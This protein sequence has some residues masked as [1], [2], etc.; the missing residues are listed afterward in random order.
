MA[1][2][3][4]QSVTDVAHIENADQ[5]LEEMLHDQYM[6]ARRALI[7]KLQGRKAQTVRLIMRLEAEVSEANLP[8]PSNE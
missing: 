1:T 8:A 4:S 3:D 6:H 5:S 2:L 7:V